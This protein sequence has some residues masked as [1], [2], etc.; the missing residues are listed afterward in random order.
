L[1][2]RREA[3]DSAVTVKA[4]QQHIVLIWKWNKRVLAKYKDYY[5]LSLHQGPLVGRLIR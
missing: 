3:A 2:I 4:K 5:S 1:E